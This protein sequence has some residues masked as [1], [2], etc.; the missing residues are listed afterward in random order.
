MLDPGLEVDLVIVP[1]GSLGMLTSHGVSWREITTAGRTWFQGAA[2][3]SAT[4]PAAVAAALGDHWVLVQ[5]AS[6]GFG[7]APRLAQLDTGIPGV[8]FAAKPGL[9]NIG[10]VSLGGRRVVEL[11]SKR[12]IYDVL[13]TGTPYP[14][15]WLE[16]E[17]P[18]PDGKPCGITIDG[19]DAPVTVTAPSNPLPGP[20][21]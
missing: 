19:F 4:E 12:D 14:V 10:E 6:S 11:R 18:G 16:V 9:Q 7:L 20:T 5:S 2:L 1:G 13:A 17:N 3:W 21:D 15:R 8:V